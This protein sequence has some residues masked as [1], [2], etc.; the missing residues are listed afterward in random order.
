MKWP[1]LKAVSTK[2][3]T[4]KLR[5]VFTDQIGSKTLSVSDKMSDE[6]YKIL[7]LNVQTLSRIKLNYLVGLLMI[8]D[9]ILMN[10]INHQQLLLNEIDKDVCQYHFDFNTPRLGMICRNS[11]K[12]EY[13]GPGL[14]MEQ[15]RARNSQ[16]A[17]QTNQYRFTLINNKSFEIE[18]VYVVPDANAKNSR[19]VGKYFDNQGNTSKRFSM[20]I[21]SNLG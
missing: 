1:V 6:P 5:S 17:V 16:T 11:I 2:V 7:F 14:V 18:N 20:Y 21:F 12:F 4:F 15:A 3:F 8:Y 13:C 9:V 19:F 10:E